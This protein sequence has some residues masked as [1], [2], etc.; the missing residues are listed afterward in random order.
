MPLTPQDRRHL[1]GRLSR[2]IA[3]QSKIGAWEPSLGYQAA[4]ENRIQATARRLEPGA[5]NV[6]IH[7][8]GSA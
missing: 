2:D 4:L 8:R 1:R 5:P 6:A 7:G 3:E